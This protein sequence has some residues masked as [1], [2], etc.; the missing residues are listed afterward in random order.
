MESPRF[1]APLPCTDFREVSS[2]E[3]IDEKDAGINDEMGDRL[4]DTD[5]DEGTTE[6]V[7]FKPPV[8]VKKG[9]KLKKK[10][11]EFHLG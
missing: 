2:G 1:G 5:V 8:S 11:E 6:S 7:F 3:C 9:R 4:E 10:I